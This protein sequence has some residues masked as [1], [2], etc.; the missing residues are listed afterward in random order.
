MLRCS[1]H[2]QIC[3]QRGTVFRWAPSQH[4]SLMWTQRTMNKKKKIWESRLVN[5]CLLTVAEYAM[6]CGAV[7]CK[8]E[9]IFAYA[10]FPSTRRW[11]FWQ[12][13]HWALSQCR[14]PDS[15]ELHWLW[16]R[17]INVPLS[18]WTWSSMPLDMTSV[19]SCLG[20]VFSFLTSIPIFSS[21]LFIIKSFLSRLLSMSFGVKS[22]SAQEP[23]SISI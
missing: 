19:F 7:N 21:W 14:S 15:E 4:P 1:S 11:V 8:C 22:A 9:F 5:F 18:S 2:F 16:W 6:I 20:G 23:K 3:A 13:L 10:C 12:W 17:W